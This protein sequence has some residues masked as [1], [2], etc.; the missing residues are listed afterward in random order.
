ML[1]QRLARMD[2]A[3]ITLTSVAVLTYAGVA[4]SY[5]HAKPNVAVDFA[6]HVPS[7]RMQVYLVAAAVV[8]NVCLVA[9]VVH[10]LA[11]AETTAF[12][13]YT[14][15]VCIG[16]YNVLQLLYFPLLRRRANGR[17]WRAAMPLLLWMCVV[18]L[19]VLTRVTSSVLVGI[20]AAHA[21][22]NDAFLYGLLLF[23][24]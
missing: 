16:T 9:Y 6:D 17:A 10:A 1:K 19:L 4:A 7:R 11:S 13:R 24:S 5:V 12:V 8:A 14:S 3:S 15:A 22:V 2:A 23:P 21:V 20:A 18:P